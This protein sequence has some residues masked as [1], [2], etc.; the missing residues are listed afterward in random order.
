MTEIIESQAIFPAHRQPRMVP[1]LLPEEIQSARDL[2]RTLQRNEDQLDDIVTFGS[3]SQ[4][5]LGQITRRMLDGVR[6]SRMDDVLQLSDGVLTQI[7]SIQLADLDAAARRYLWLL[8]E[9]TAAI[10]HRVKKFFKDFETIDTRLDRMEADV[11]TRESESTHRYNQDVELGKAAAEVLR[12]ARIKIAAIELFLDG[13]Y[14]Y[15]ALERRQ[16]AVIEERVAAKHENR[17]IN[18]EIVRAADRYARYIERLEEKKAS[19]YNL[20][21]SVTHVLASIT[22]L[23]DNENTIRQKLSD[24][25]LD[26]LPQWRTFISL[27]W[28]GYQQR[29]IAG[30]VQSINSAN[31]TLRSKVGDQ[32]EKT[33]LEIRQVKIQQTTS[34]DAMMYYHEK[35]VSS[36]EILRAASIEAKQNRDRAEETAMEYITKLGDAVAKTS[37]NTK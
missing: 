28:Q 34:P 19:L 15:R 2:S 20:Y 25:R 30:V 1:T 26:L 27:A 11:F 24:I 14:G 23:Q 16:Q 37:L 13:D 10:E 9:S 32:L 4:A 5:A 35:L 22:M 29:G 36:L 7:G 33:A 21:E 6:S 12:D 17:P 8:R 18:F 31:D 3:D